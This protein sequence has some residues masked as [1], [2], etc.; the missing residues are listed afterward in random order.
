MIGVNNGS[1]F[2]L[3]RIVGYKQSYATAEVKL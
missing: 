1:I 3:L 2:G